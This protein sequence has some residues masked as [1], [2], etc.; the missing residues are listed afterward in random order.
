MVFT[1]EVRARLG[2][3]AEKRFKD[4]RRHQQHGASEA[5]VAKRFKVVQQALGDL[6]NS[7][8]A[9]D[10][11]LAREVEHVSGLL[12]RVEKRLQTG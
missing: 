1:E 2:A 4:V 12:R 9:Q 5:Q 6:E 3:L 8:R 10:P 11:A 7:L